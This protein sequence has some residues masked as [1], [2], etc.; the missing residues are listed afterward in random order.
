MVVPA[1]MMAAIPAI[2]AAMVPVMAAVIVMT[3]IVV[4]VI[5]VA[6][7]IVA[8]IVAVHVVPG[9][10][11]TAGAA[12]SPPSAIAAAAANVISFI[13][14]LPWDFPCAL[15]RS[16]RRLG[17]GVRERIYSASSPPARGT[18]HGL[19]QPANPARYGARGERAGHERGRSRGG[20]GP[21]SAAALL[22]L[23]A[24]PRRRA[25]CCAPSSARSTRTSGPRAPRAIAPGSKR[26]SRAR[27]AVSGVA[28]LDAHG[29]AEV[30]EDRH[31]FWP[32]AGDFMIWNQLLAQPD[33]CRQRL[34]FALSQFFVISLNAIDGY[35]PPYIMA[36]WWD[37]LMDG[38]FGNFRTCSS[39]SRSTPA[40][41][42][43]ST[44]RAI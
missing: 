18:G 14:S 2:V 22:A 3:V 37:V 25:S 29:H 38:A 19:T 44:P 9:G 7:V 26:S 1:I 16:A 34:A 31:Y 10:W 42:C 35:W 11:A 23:S 32:Q 12:V 28:W 13:M 6:V 41:A 40:W 15:Q 33:Q 43:T 17:P 39:G 24:R 27:A 20:A 5:V 8:H 36:A 4:P 30:R 21:G